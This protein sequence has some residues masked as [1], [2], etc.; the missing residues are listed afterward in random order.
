MD[1][2]FGS[3][4]VTRD[5]L[6][7]SS[8]LSRLTVTRWWKNDVIIQ[9]SPSRPVRR[10]RGWWSSPSCCWSPG[11]TGLCGGCW[12]PPRPAR[13][14]C[15][16]TPAGARRSQTPAASSPRGWSPWRHNETTLRMNPLCE[17]D[18]IDQTF[19]LVW[20]HWHFISSSME[21]VKSQSDEHLSP[22]S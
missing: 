13:P 9:G 3:K 2:Q 10:C 15:C 5:T 6:Q 20:S 12:Q 19:D 14:R 18:I 11:R 21:N 7:S 22:V 1:Q 16:W 4:T 17:A 8:R